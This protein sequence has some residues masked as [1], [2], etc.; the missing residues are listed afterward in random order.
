MV[1]V[2]DVRRSLVI[3]PVFIGRDAVI[4]KGAV[5]GPLAVVGASSVVEPARRYQ[6]VCC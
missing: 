5:I 3:P 1:R 2:P 6:P 4:G